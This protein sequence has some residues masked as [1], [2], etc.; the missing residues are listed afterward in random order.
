[1]TEQNPLP[2]AQQTFIDALGFRTQGS[3]TLPIEQAL[4]R[5]LFSPVTAPIDS[6]PYPRSI[7]EG[8]LVDVS[9]TQSASEE[10][11]VSFD[12]IG[13]VNPGDSQCPLPAAGQAV[14]VATGSVVAQ[15]NVAIA[16]MWEVEV[17]GSTVKVK[18]PFPPNFFIEEQGCDIK[19]GNEILDAGTVIDPQAIG[20]LASMG[21]AEVTVCSAPR[22]AVF[23]SG[24]EVIPHTSPFRVGAIFDCN[25][26]ML[27]A[28]VAANGG[29]AVSEG[30]QGDDFDSFVGKVKTALVENDML[31]ISGG[32]AVGGRDF[33]SDLIREVG[34]LIIDGVPMKSGRP[35]IMGVAN[36]KPIVCVAGHPPEAL[37]GFRLFGVAAIDRL[38]GRN[39]DLPADNN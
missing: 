14:E 23:A 36:G 22:V 11:P 12:I 10:N 39:T 17:D 24:D 37:R 34:E 25:T 9:A 18:R 16:R 33:I 26:P 7:V 19:K 38:L 32:T 4:G 35:L 13:Q 20:T 1:M 15:G 28:A 21:I 31:V 6:P 27:A 8:Y 30:I 5:T 29:I 3:E 2:Q